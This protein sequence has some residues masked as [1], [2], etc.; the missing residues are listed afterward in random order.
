LGRLVANVVSDHSHCL[1]QENWILKNVLLMVLLVCDKLC[2]IYQTSHKLLTELSF[3]S[4]LQN[5]WWHY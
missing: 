5:L 1:L 4:W 2:P 3:T